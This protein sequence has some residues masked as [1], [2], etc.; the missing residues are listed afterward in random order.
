MFSNRT[1]TRASCKSSHWNK[2]EPD[3]FAWIFLRNVTNS[4]R[5]WQIRSEIVKIAN[6][7]RAAG[8]DLA[9]P[10]LGSQHLPTSAK[11]AMIMTEKHQWMKEFGDWDELVQQMIFQLLT[12]KHEI[13]LSHQAKHQAL[14]WSMF[15]LWTWNEA[16]IVKKNFRR[17]KLVISAEIEKVPIRIWKLIQST[18]PTWNQPNYQHHGHI[19]CEML[20]EGNE[21]W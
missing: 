10:A 17:G 18:S 1:L 5:N 20:G 16:E 7:N 3:M 12:R 21:L 2:C 6:K 8:S 13:T 19:V 15:S 4:Q 11:W 9:T 14:G